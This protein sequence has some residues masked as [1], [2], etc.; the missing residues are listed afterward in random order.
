MIKKQT[1]FANSNVGKKE[2][3]CVDVLSG[4]RNQEK[5]SIDPSTAASLLLGGRNRSFGVSSSADFLVPMEIATKG[6]Y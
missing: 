3:S 1:L 6:P 2:L 5:R 4:E